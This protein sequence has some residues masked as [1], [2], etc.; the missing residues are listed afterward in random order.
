ME[1][2]AVV[3]QE[4][5]CAAMQRILEELFDSL[6][7]CWIL[8]RLEASGSDIEVTHRDA[9]VEERGRVDVEGKERRM[10]AEEGNLN[11][12]LTNV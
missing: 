2:T 6:F 4:G 3:A 9:A 1:D 5:W 8:L 7:V 11:S 12:Q 10:E